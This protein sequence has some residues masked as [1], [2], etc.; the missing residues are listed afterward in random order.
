MR[1]GVDLGP[2][3]TS[4]AF[5]R[6]YIARFFSGVGN[7][8]TY[9]V[10]A[11]QLRLLTHSVL[12]VG[13]LGLVEVIPIVVFGLYGGVLADHLDRRVMAVATEVAL[14]LLSVSLLVNTLWHPHAWVLYA[15]DAL[16]V[17]AGSLQTPSVAAMR[18]LLVRHDEQRSAATLGAIRDTT[19]TLVA[20]A[21][22]G[23]IAVLAGPG[24]A[25]L[26]TVVAFTVS[27]PL[28]ASLPQPPRGGGGSAVAASLRTG[29]RYTHSRPDLIGTYVVDL[30]AMAWAYP[31][32]MLPFVAATFPHQP[33]ALA[34]L[35]LGLPLGS[36]LATLSAAWTRHVHRYGRAIV[37][38]AVVWGGGITLFGFSRSLTMDLV[39]L[40]IAGGADAMSGIFRTTMW[41]ESIPPDVRG[42]LAGVELISY[43]LGPTT[44]QLRSGWMAAWWSLRLS[45]GLGGIGAAGSVAGV[46][47]A[48]PRLWSFDARTDENVAAVARQRAAA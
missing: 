40:T 2:L 17:S 12:A 42:R 19:A 3:R 10:T 33:D 39:G 15:V 36:L 4:P 47:V 20:P 16:V 13:S 34:L 18:Q 21:I 30:L 48:L 35:Y 8:L 9:V 28:L 37:V 43:A 23:L 7:Q 32:V 41:N 46:A 24:W 14:G 44:G 26:V 11:Y 45:L 22:G 6:L 25:Y 5:R 27:V 1:G 29:L 38:A 31:V